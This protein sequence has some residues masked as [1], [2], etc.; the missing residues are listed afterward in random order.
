MLQFHASPLFGLILFFLV[1]VSVSLIKINSESAAQPQIVAP[2]QLQ[3]TMQ[4]SFFCAIRYIQ[5]T[6][7]L[8]NG[9]TVFMGF[10]VLWCAGVLVYSDCEWASVC[11]LFI[12]FIHAISTPVHRL[13]FHIF[14]RS[15]HLFHFNSFYFSLSLI[16][17][18]IKSHAATNK[19]AAEMG[20]E[21]ARIVILTF[22]PRSRYCCN[23]KK[24]VRIIVVWW[25][26]LFLLRN[27]KISL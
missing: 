26:L 16:Y 7:G 19:T 8:V 23:C 2:N 22:I 27:F 15:F 17:S 24:R 14:V 1:S 13:S 12:P 20:G 6:F 9:T 25:L 11:G 5:R 18:F 10:L 4:I 21:K 3:N